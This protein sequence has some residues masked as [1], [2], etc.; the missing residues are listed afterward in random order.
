M[1][2]RLMRAQ[3]PSGARDR[4]A[5]QNSVVTG[6]VIRKHN[7][8]VIFQKALLAIAAAIQREVED[9]MWLS[10]VAG[11]NP[12]TCI[13]RFSFV[14]HGQDGVVGGHHMRGAYAIRHQL[15]ERLNEV[16]YIVSPHRLRSAQD[17]EALPRK[18][19]FKPVKWKVITEFASYDATQ[20]TRSRSPLSI[21]ASGFFAA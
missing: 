20:Q 3:H 5:N 10:L 15:I 12:H 14:L 9:V 4:I 16:R 19:I 11:V 13:R 17:I 6:I 2:L 8:V 7:L 1:I 18:N 21:A